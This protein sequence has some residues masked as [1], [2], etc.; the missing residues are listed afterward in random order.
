MTTERPD[1]FSCPVCKY[2]FPF[3]DA[4]KHVTYLGDGPVLE[5]E[6]PECDSILLV[7]ESVTREFAVS[8][9]LKGSDREES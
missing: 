6:C 4:V 3:E 8:V 7:S 1:T 2:Q 9:I 5:D